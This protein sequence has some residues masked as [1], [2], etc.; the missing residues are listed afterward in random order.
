MALLL[1]SPGSQVIA[2]IIWELWENG[3]VSTLAVLFHRLT[4]RYSLQV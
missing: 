1:Y 3:N 4:R 2:V